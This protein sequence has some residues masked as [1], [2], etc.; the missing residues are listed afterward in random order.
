MDKA[1]GLLKKNW[2]YLAGGGLG[3]AGGFLYWYNIGCASGAC[4]ITSSPVMSTIWGALMGGLLF[5]AIFSKSGRSKSNSGNAEA[6]VISG[7]KK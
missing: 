7:G 2:Y 5:G 3:G 4:P 6:G 1:L